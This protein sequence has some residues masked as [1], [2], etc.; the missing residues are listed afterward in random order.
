MATENRHGWR[1]ARARRR[2]THNQRVLYTETELRRCH[3]CAH[4]SF[5]SVLCYVWSKTVSVKVGGILYMYMIERRIWH[6]LSLLNTE[7]VTLWTTKWCLFQ[8]FNVAGALIVI[9]PTCQQALF[10][11]NLAEDPT[12]HSKLKLGWSHYKAGGVFIYIWLF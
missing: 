12:T 8:V 9:Q 4:L 2:W 6:M 1:T 10:S 11:W 3:K 5:M 7:W